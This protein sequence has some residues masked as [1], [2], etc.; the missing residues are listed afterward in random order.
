MSPSEEDT[1][2]GS[3]M[4]RGNALLAETN[5]TGRPLA[6]DF[7]LTRLAFQRCHA[8]HPSYAT[9]EAWG[10]NA[11]PGKESHDLRCTLCIVVR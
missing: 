7:C 9:E 10:W 11:A 3:A 1:V 5:P 6:I 2:T 4:L 8:F